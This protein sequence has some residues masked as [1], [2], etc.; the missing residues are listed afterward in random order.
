MGEESYGS[1]MRL[2]SGSS[3]TD[4]WAYVIT[5]SNVQVNEYSLIA[6][7]GWI[8]TKLRINVEGWNDVIVVPQRL[9]PVLEETIGDKIVKASSLLRALII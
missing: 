2:P 5:L 7:R 8:R 9:I 1:I 3:D 4:I 6:L